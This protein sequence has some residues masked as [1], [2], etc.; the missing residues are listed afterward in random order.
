L[1][2]SQESKPFLQFETLRSRLVTSTSAVCDGLNFERS[3]A[4]RPAWQAARFCTRSDDCANEKAGQKTRQANNAQRHQRKLTDICL[5]LSKLSN[6]DRNRTRVSVSLKKPPR[7]LTTAYFL[8]SLA[9]AM[10]ACWPASV[11]AFK[12]ASTLFGVGPFPERMVRNS[13]CLP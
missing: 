4:S 2:W 6:A 8:S 1:E 12:N 11:T 13:M 7:K 5:R 10:R 9:S 3:Q